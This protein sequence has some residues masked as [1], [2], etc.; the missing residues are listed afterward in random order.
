MPK[1]TIKT[2]K[3]VDVK[4]LQA[5]CKVRY[6]EGGKVNGVEDSNGTLIPCRKGDN[7]KPMVNLDTGQIEGW[8]DGV[9]AS[10][11]YKVC[12]AGIYTLLDANRNEVAKKDGYVPGMMCPG[13]N[14]YGDYV[15]M[16][17]RPDGTIDRFEPDFSEFEADE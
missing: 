17:I 14:G 11:H 10:V 6:W 3:T 9:S 12:D 8:P 2:T 13:G 7:W 5:S 4:Y 15:I 16:T 1:L